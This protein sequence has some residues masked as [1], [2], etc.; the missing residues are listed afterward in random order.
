MRTRRII[1]LWTAIG[2]ALVFGLPFF[3][4]ASGTQASSERT[5]AAS[6]LNTR[7][8]EVIAR[9]YQNP[10]IE[11]ARALKGEALIRALRQ[12]GYVLY[13]RHTQTGTVT[14]ECKTSNLT[15]AGERDARFVGESIRALR[16][17]I[18]RILSSPICRVFDT[19]KLLALGDVETTFDLSN[20]PSAGV[21]NLE[22]ARLKQLQA[23][24]AKGKNR[25]LVSHL[26][27]GEV[28]QDQL[29][30][31]FGEVLVVRPASQNPIMVLARIR[32]DDWN[33][34]NEGS[35]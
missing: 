19:A 27:H 2:T 4:Q 20:L 12:G 29:A 32:V 16:I 13:M 23:E 5:L 25:M 14:P 10:K 11:A 17:P 15:T 26:Q 35:R 24:P 3:A 30:L 8:P 7:D 28:E 34:L 33:D 22:Q 31:D 9:A 6:E 18:D 1:I 21:P